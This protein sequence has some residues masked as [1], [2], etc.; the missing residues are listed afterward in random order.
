M[1]RLKNKTL[2]AAAVAAVLL[3]MGGV[4][5]II[6]VSSDSEEEPTGPV[7]GSDSEE[8][9]TNP[10]ADDLQNKTLVIGRSVERGDYKLTVI[11][12]NCSESED[13]C[14]MN[15]E[16]EN[17]GDEDG[18]FPDGCKWEPYPEDYL[19][20]V[21]PD[22]GP[23]KVVLA[24][25]PDPNE[26][27]TCT[28]A[29]VPFPIGDTARGSLRFDLPTDTRLIK[30]LIISSGGSADSIV[31]DQLY[32]PQDITESDQ[33]IKLGEAFSWGEYY[34]GL[35]ADYAYEGSLSD[36]T[37]EGRICA[38]S[39]SITY[40]KQTPNLNW[41]DHI[42]D[43]GG[44]VKYDVDLS[45]LYSLEGADNLEII[46]ENTD[47]R[48][49]TLESSGQPCTERKGLEFQLDETIRLEKSFELPAN[50]SAEYIK[51]TS[52]RVF[53]EGSSTK[54]IRVKSH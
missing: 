48:R 43:C 27:P 52:D 40:K 12:L 24:Q 3:V 8:E 51:I 15:L 10:G 17:I 42:Y 30:E 32:V 54:Y 49:L 44:Y 23:L 21:R 26:R 14:L 47:L 9:P 50:A 22:D 31:L 37:C 4:I 5:G 36:F 11:D 45:L 19:L 18:Y 33:A 38:V 35:N 13:S 46:D 53:F 39:Q 29:I 6:V 7:T 34:T 28:L 25:W 2:L 16:L 41:G 20:R 1:K